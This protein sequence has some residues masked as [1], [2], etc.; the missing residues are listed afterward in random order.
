MV[1]ARLATMEQDERTNL[2][3]SANFQKVSRSAAAE[4]LNVGTRTAASAATVRNEG[5]A[6]AVIETVTATKY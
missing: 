2:E 6:G 4:M 3:P 5:M 1:V